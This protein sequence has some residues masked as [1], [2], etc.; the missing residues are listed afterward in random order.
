MNSPVFYL[1]FV[2]AATELCTDDELVSLLET[3]RANNIKRGITGLLLYYEGSFLEI[4]EGPQKTIEWLFNEKVS[5]DRRH[6]CVV[7]LLTGTEDHRSFPDW[8]M[9]F[10]RITKEIIQEQIPNFNSILESHS[11]PEKVFPDIYTPLLIFLR[12]FYRS[13]GYSTHG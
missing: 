10:K 6:H 7:K 8:S 4:I 9:G 5:H 1:V 11:N 13:S 2:S 12:S 3:C